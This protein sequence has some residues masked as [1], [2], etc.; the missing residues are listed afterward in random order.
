MPWWC[1]LSAALRSS[2]GLS[3][4]GETSA[5]QEVKSS[6]QP[7]AIYLRR[8]TWQRCHCWFPAWLGLTWWTAGPWPCC[9]PHHCR[10][11]QLAS[12]C[13]SSR[14]GRCLS[15]PSDPACESWGERVEVRW[16]GGKGREGRGG[17][18]GRVECETQTTQSLS[19]WQLSSVCTWWACPWGWWSHSGRCFQLERERHTHTHRQTDVRVKKTRRGLTICCAQT[20]APSATPQGY[21]RPRTL[22][23]FTS[24]MVLL[25]TTASGSL[26]YKEETG[27]IRCFLTFWLNASLKVQ[28]VKIGLTVEINSPNLPDSFLSILLIQ[29][30]ELS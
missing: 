25:P 7:G 28:C 20:A 6:T 30:N 22:L 2:P 16:G 5:L 19:D 9:C 17:G 1:T 23:P 14:S 12:C 10:W 27:N 13:G 4:S 15:R 11:R 21:C 3:C 8:T 26:S 24:M 29:K 18:G